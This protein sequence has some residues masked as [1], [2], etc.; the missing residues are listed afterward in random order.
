MYLI[1]LG[2]AKFRKIFYRLVDGSDIDEN[3]QRLRT[4]EAEVFTVI[5]EDKSF[6]DSWEGNLEQHKMADMKIAGAIRNSFRLYEKNK[7]EDID[8]MYFDF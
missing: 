1:S 7:Q 2:V 4:I 3:I 5:R 6:G 8:I